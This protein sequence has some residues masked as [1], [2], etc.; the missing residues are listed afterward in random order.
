MNL[1]R[2]KLLFLFALLQV[3]CINS[4]SQDTSSGYNAINWNLFYKDAFTSLTYGLPL[5]FY[6][7]INDY[8]SMGNALSTFQFTSNNFYH[9]H[10]SISNFTTELI[11]SPYVNYNG[12]RIDSLIELNYSYNE[13]PDHLAY[14]YYL[15]R[16]Q[17]NDV[18]FF[19]IPGSN[20]NQSYLIYYKS[21][22]VYDA[23]KN[24]HGDIA[25]LTASLGDTYIY[26]KPNEDALALHDST[27]YYK[28]NDS[29][30]YN[31]LLTQNTPY[32]AN[33]LVDCI[34]YVK[35]LKKKYKKVIVVGLSQGGLA[36]MIVSLITHP[37]ASVV[38]TGYSVLFDNAYSA[39]I[40]QLNIPG[41]FNTFSSDSVRRNIKNN[42]TQYFFSWGKN[43]TYA[44]Y[45]N[46]NI[47][48]ITENYFN[49][50]IHTSYFYNFYN[51]V[52]PRPQ[53]DS[54]LYEMVARPKVDVM[55]KKTDCIS[56]SVLLKL[57]FS[58]DVPP[59]S[60]DIIKNDTL[61]QSYSIN[62]SLKEININQSGKYKIAN[63]KGG[64]GIAGLESQTFK[65]NVNTFTPVF[66]PLVYDTLRNEVILSYRLNADEDTVILKYRCDA[67]TT[68]T[69]SKTLTE[70]VGSVSFPPGY[71]LIDSLL[72]NGKCNFPL[73]IFINASKAYLEDLTRYD[74]CSQ[75][76]KLRVTFKG[77][78]PFH[79]TLMKDS[80]VLSENLLSTTGDTILSL[81]NAGLFQVTN[82]TGNG[83]QI[84]FDSDTMSVTFEKL[85]KPDITIKFNDITLTTDTTDQLIRWYFNGE[86][87]DGSDN[88][89]SITAVGA[90]NYKA[91]LSS[92]LGCTLSSNT[93][94]YLGGGY[95]QILPNPAHSDITISLDDNRNSS[96]NLLVYKMNGQLILNEIITG[97]VS[98]L[99][100][101]RWPKGSYVEN[102]INLW[103]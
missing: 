84:G 36:S 45:Q 8:N 44:G 24:Y 66:D 37:T 49:D 85:P 81:T 73:N 59:Y 31:N 68:V 48:H 54:F 101:S 92:K 55:I 87:I 79:Y 57:N 3:M 56:D 61:F 21:D 38:S 40:D 33:Y 17:A 71:Y 78:P 89:I 47:N 99:D 50:S 53:V 32:G 29:Y 67:D 19:I 26:I 64:S 52:F 65:V 18:A 95:L 15:Q 60:F 27:T 83:D 13:T 93:V 74:D 102:Y 30:L 20:P 7:K 80:A 35:Y 70:K 43:E 39:G 5:Y 2:N 100:V 103:N 28:L 14:A 10:K 91:I 62:N 11:T 12:P 90:G 22:P 46:E 94:E 88:Q 51:H 98:S 6:P 86:H 34:A 42:Q 16:Q 97:K 23:L 72:F 9:A 96:Y 25:K 77:M 41:L 58:S 76:R 82:I 63:I 69:L 1:I 4:Y 75:I